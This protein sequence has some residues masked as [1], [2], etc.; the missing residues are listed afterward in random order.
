VYPHRCNESTDSARVRALVLSVGLGHV[1]DEWG[2]SKPSD[3]LR[4]LGKGELQALSFARILYHRPRFGL[5]D[6]ATSA[7]DVD[8]ESKLMGMC[9]DAGITAISV[10]HRPS[11]ICLH[12]NMLEYTGASVGSNLDPRSWRVRPVPEADRAVGI[13]RL[14]EFKANGQGDGASSFS[15]MASFLPS[16]QNARTSLDEEAGMGRVFIERLLGLLHRSIPTLT[17]YPV[18]CILVV[19]VGNIIFGFFIYAVTSR[20]ADFYVGLASGKVSRDAWVLV[21]FGLVGPFVLVLD[22]LIAF[23]GQT[24]ALHVRRVATYEG[25]NNYFRWKVPYAMNC[26]PT[27]CVP[28][29]VTH[30]QPDQRLQNDMQQLYDSLSSSLFGGCTTKGIVGAFIELTIGLSIGFSLSW[31]MVLLIVLWVVMNGACSYFVLPLIT[32][33]AMKMQSAE[34][35]LRNAHALVREFTESIVFYGGQEEESRRCNVLLE[36]KVAYARY[37]LA[38]RAIP[39]TFFGVSM[40]LGNS[41]LIV[42][43]LSSIVFFRPDMPMSPVNFGLASSYF[44]STTGQ[45]TFIALAWAQLGTLAG[46][47]HR[48]CGFLEASKKAGDWVTQDGSRIALNDTSEVAAVEL[49]VQAPAMRLPTGG[50]SEPLVVIKNLSAKVPSGAGLVIDGKSGAGKSSLFRVLA[51]LWSPASGHVARPPIMGG[52]FFV[53]QAAYAT[54]GTLQEQ[55]IYP[56]QD[57]ERKRAFECLQAVGLEYLAE[58]F[59]MNGPSAWAE[60]L[61]GGEMQRLGLARVLYH[62]QSFAFLDESTSALNVALEQHCLEAIGRAGITPISISVRPTSHAFHDQLLTLAGTPEDGKWTITKRSVAVAGE[63]VAGAVAGEDPLHED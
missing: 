61:S 33:G 20:M 3:W 28:G 11:A 31:M 46:F 26:M 58:R 40:V 62:R 39:A 22:F 36:E 4:V 15:S 43:S 30:W 23:A 21:F 14:Q 5:M 60:H 1:V 24:L 59:G 13:A 6:E 44:L 56:L 9:A 25:H 7:L 18:L 63:D 52:S 37:S 34:G 12:Y 38:I 17:G 8:T 53:G 42:I 16:P 41:A 45:V 49:N 32:E 48:V 47:V 35:A 51:G 27:Q 19:V 54:E 50:L 55:V 2:L 29:P 10:C 57:G